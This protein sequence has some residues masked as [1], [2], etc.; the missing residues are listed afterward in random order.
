MLDAAPQ[1]LLAL[2][3]EKFFNCCIIHHHAKKNDKNIFCL[4]CSLG[5]CPHCL[6]LHPSH[7]LLQI[8]RY[9]YHEVIRIVDADELIDC[10][11]IQTYTNNGAKVV[12]LKQRPLN[13]PPRASARICVGCDRNLPE[14]ALFCSISCK[15]DHMVETGGKLCIHVPNSEFLALPLDD[16]QMTPDSV[17]SMR[18]D[19]G[20]SSGGLAD[21]MYLNS[22][23]TSEAVKGKRSVPTGFG[24]GC[25][26]ASEY[27][28]NRRKGTP[29]RSPLH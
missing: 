20:S 8:R 11:H 2:L 25:R 9:V 23:A 10:T 4:D 3:S 13:R 1:W 15:L 16:G 19:S 6:P 18:T 17:L 22:T 24:P 7:R 21:C 27:I 29:H 28:M 5:I 26:P 12:F 14:S